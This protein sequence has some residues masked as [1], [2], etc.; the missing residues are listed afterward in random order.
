M[1]NSSIQ[2]ETISFRIDPALKAALVKM[3]EQEAKPVGQLL[4]ELVRERLEKKLRREFEADARR[5]SLEIAAAARDLNSDEAAV[6]R[7]LD[8][9]FD[10]SIREWK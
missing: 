9:L 6:M 3:A 7:E 4:R 5:Q 2:A 10:E 8:A 1:S